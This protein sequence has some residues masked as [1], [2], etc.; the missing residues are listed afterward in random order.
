MRHGLIERDAS[1]KGKEMD[2]ST[3]ADVNATEL[4]F[5]EA[6]VAFAKG[7]NHPKDLFPRGDGCTS[8]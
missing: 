7:K 8:P 2:M 1:K 6:D 3:E 5:L 4:R